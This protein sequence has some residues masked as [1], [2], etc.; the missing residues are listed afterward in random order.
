MMRALLW[1]IGLLAG[2]ACILLGLAG[3]AI[4]AVAIFDPA[5]AQMADDNNPFGAPPTFSESLGQLG[6]FLALTLVGAALL[7]LV[8]KGIRLNH[9][10][11]RCS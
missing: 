3:V 11:R 9:L 10:T 6:G 4:S 2:A 1:L 8:W 7:W 5:G